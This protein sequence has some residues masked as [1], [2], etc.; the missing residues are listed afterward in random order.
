[1][2]DIRKALKRYEESIGNTYRQKEEVDSEIGRTLGEIEEI[3]KHIEAYQKKIKDIEERQE[4]RK[5]ETNRNH[6]R[7]AQSEATPRFNTSIA[8]YAIPKLDLSKNK[9]NTLIPA[10]P[11]EFIHERLNEIDNNNTE[12][13]I[14]STESTDIIT[15]SK[16]TNGSGI[17]ADYHSFKTL[18]Q[19]LQ[20]L[21]KE[22]EELRNFSDP[23][24]VKTKKRKSVYQFFAKKM[25][26]NA[27][28]RQNLLSKLNADKQKRRK[29]SI[30]L[31]KIQR[32]KRPIR[33]L[34]MLFLDSKPDSKGVK[35]HIDRFWKK[36]SESKR[37]SIEEF[38]HKL[39]L[40][41]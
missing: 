21:T 22:K 35:D 17:A 7:R 2:E 25:K 4:T 5:N 1:M 34:N 28:L 33:T 24:G 27:Q 31:V 40:N 6:H 26:G 38:K 20:T 9:R 32:K 37:L 23:I 12:R 39:N 19:N 10:L 36:G 18:P 30:D 15:N 41:I 16:M 29:M 14:V 13:T 11:L 3:K 8:P